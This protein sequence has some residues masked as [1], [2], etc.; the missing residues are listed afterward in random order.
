[1]ASKSTFSHTDSQGRDIGTRIKAFGYQGQRVGENIAGGLEHATDN[2]TIWQSDD[3]HKN[4]LLGTNYSRAG[5]GR[6]YS[7]TAQNRWNWV[8]DLG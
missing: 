1:M 3:I 6:Y 4:N 7:P 8:L 5:V 2:L